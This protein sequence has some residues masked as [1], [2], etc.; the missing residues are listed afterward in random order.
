MASPAP[1][2]VR[3]R[4]ERDSDVSDAA[5]GY[6]YNSENGEDVSGG[7]QDQMVKNLVRLALACEYTRQPLRRA[8]ITAK[9]IY[10]H[11]AT[12]AVLNLSQS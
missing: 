2:S 8:D 6:D 3:Q 11:F 5:S 7:L 4:R 1:R 9:G 10:A 12:R